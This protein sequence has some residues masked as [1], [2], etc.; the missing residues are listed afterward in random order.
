MSDNNEKLEIL[1]E[2]KDTF[3]VDNSE[4]PINEET[5]SHKEESKNSTIINGDNNGSIN[6]AESQTIHNYYNEEKPSKPV[7]VHNIP[8]EIKEAAQTTI[9][10]HNREH[11]DDSALEQGRKKTTKRTCGDLVEKAN[12]TPKEHRAF[13]SKEW[14][15]I[16][17][18]T[19]AYNWTPF[20]FRTTEGLERRVREDRRINKSN[21]NSKRKER[22]SS[23][24]RQDDVEK[25]EDVVIYIIIMC[26]IVLFLVGLTFFCVRH[27]LQ[28]I[29]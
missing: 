24:R 25:R 3:N 21:P 11:F 18:R 2:I 27:A 16:E 7:N 20:N 22:R 13:I 5:S 8:E 26:F 15:G 1:K 17:M 4:S 10:K 14:N 29:S 19:N 6:N 9:D 12:M 28:G 23:P